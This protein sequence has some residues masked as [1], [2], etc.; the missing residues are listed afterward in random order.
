MIVS[1]AAA[2][3]ATTAVV[4]KNLPDRSIPITFAAILSAGMGLS[5]PVRGHVVKEQSA[6]AGGHVAAPLRPVGA[7]AGVHLRRVLADALVAAVGAEVAAR[8]PADVV[9]RFTA[10]LAS[11]STG[12]RS[13][14]CQRAYRAVIRVLIV[15]PSPPGDMSC[16]AIA[17]PV[18]CP[19][20]RWLSLSR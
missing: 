19:Q 6:D 3:E 7:A 15:P 5:V 11:G 16:A 1:P 8:E 10:A 18:R 12:G 4:T 2:G 20:T 14:H 17:R 13:S 9:A